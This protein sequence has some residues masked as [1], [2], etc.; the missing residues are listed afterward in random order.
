M[1]QL[2]LSSALVYIPLMAMKPILARVI[3]SGG[4]A[5]IFIDW[6]LRST[7]LTPSVTSNETL[8]LCTV[9]I[10]QDV[11]RVII[12]AEYK[13]PW[14]YSGDTKKILKQLNVLCIKFDL[15]YQYALFLRHNHHF[16]C[17][18]K[19][20]S[21]QTDLS[22]TLSNHLS[23]KCCLLFSSNVC[24]LM[25]SWTTDLTTLATSRL[26]TSAYDMHLDMFGLRAFLGISIS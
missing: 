11:D 6:R 4:G 9:I 1:S 24:I 20:H 13:A 14:T 3:K 10:G 17:S 12:I 26:V 8:K 5:R 25:L 2:T 22:S 15:P 7:Q 23:Q 16:Y 21:L 18:A 19:V